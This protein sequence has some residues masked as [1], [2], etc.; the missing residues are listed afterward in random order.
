MKTTLSDYIEQLCRTHK[1]IMHQDDEM[2]FTDLA[3]EEQNGYAHKMHYPCVVLDDGDFDMRE[4][5][6]QLQ[7][8]DKSS[9]MFLTH[10]RDTGDANEIRAAFALTKQLCKDF[11][12]RMLRDRK[13]GVPVMR[14]L[15]LD[16]ATGERIF[17]KDVAL[18]GYVLEFEN[19][20]IFVDLDCNNAFV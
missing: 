6:K 19:P 17:M 13:N 11:M 9:L 20:E 1:D 2:H 16:G 5:D 18:Y 15:N 4:P 8:V 10:V 14:R 3:D 7:L 12:R